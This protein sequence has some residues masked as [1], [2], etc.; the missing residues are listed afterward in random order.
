[1]VRLISYSTWASAR[2]SS[3]LGR[4]TAIQSPLTRSVSSRS[5]LEWHLSCPCGYLKADQ[6]QPQQPNRV[7]SNLRGLPNACKFSHP[8]HC[9][10]GRDNHIFV[11]TII[12][13]HLSQCLYFLFCPRHSDDQ[14][15]VFS[16]YPIGVS[17]S[18]RMRS[19]KHSPHH[20]PT[21][22]IRSGPV[23]LGT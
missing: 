11:F 13:D 9:R 23:C 15:H 14:V 16:F 21:D 7:S 18:Q 6:G 1:M 5:S 17:P 3:A 2:A 12:H 19:N 8:F 20:E 22:K 4:I 10:H